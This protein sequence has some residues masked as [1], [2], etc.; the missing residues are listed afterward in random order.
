MN[1]KKKNKILFVTGTFFPE[2]S[3]GNLQSKNFLTLLKIFYLKILTFT[4]KK[5][6]QTSKKYTK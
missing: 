6:L 3:G 1:I 4:R 5:K 2:I